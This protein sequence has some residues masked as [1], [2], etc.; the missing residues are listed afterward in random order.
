M[1]RARGQ[2]I[3]QVTKKTYKNVTKNDT[4]VSLVRLKSSNL[5]Q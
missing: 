2:N 5:A 1:G 3:K 4:M